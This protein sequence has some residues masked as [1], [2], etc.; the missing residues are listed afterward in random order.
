[1]MTRRLSCYSYTTAFV[2]EYETS[3]RSTSLVAMTC[4]TCTSLTMRCRYCRVVSCV[5]SSNADVAPGNNS[6]VSHESLV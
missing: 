5:M 2:C 1:M 6:A 3:P 4:S